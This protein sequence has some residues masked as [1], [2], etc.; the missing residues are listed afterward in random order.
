MAGRQQ[1]RAAPPGRPQR[2]PVVALYERMVE[3]IRAGTYPPGSTL[4]TEPRLA[5]ELGVSRPALREALILLQEDGVINVRRGVGRTVSH[6]PPPRGFE[7]LKPLEVLLGEGRQVVTV[8]VARTREEPTDFSTQHLVLPA[9]GEVRFWESVI[10]VGGLPAC[11]TQ[12]W[13]ADETLAELL[14]E[15]A[16]AFDGPAARTSSMLRLLLDAGRGLPLTGSSTIVATTLGR[17][18]G[19]Q[20]G[21]PAETPGVLVTQ[22]IRLDRTP[23]LAAKHMLPPGAPALPVWQAR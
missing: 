20:L 9:G 12:E 10:E 22:V 2:R 16:E 21:R 8:P 13:A 14:P 17:Q 1:D 4:P 5:A 3:A 18:R 19:A 6:H 15:A 23:L 11:L 7:F